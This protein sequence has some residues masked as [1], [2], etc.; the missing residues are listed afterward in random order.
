[1]GG[2]LFHS[3]NQAQQ[4]S[5]QGVRRMADR[6]PYRGKLRLVSGD[7]YA[8]GIQVRKDEAELYQS[9]RYCV[10]VNGHLGPHFRDAAAF[11]KAYI[12]SP[13]RSLSRLSNEHAVLIHDEQTG[14]V[15]FFTSLS[16]MRPL[17]FGHTDQQIA[18]ASE[19]RQ[20]VT[21][22]EIAARMDLEV[23]AQIA[24]EFAPVLTPWKTEFDSV[25]RCLP[26]NIYAFQAAQAEP[27][28]VGQYW[29][30]KQ[31]P[32]HDSSQDPHRLATALAATL[33]THLQGSAAFS[34]SGGL[35]SS[36]L[37]GL[38]RRHEL[39]QTSTAAHEAHAYTLSFPGRAMDETSQ[40]QDLVKSTGGNLHLIEAVQHNPSEYMETNLRL[41][42]RISG[43]ATLFYAHLLGERL[44]CDGMTQHISGI[45]AELWMTA[46]NHFPRDTL[47]AG[48]PLSALKQSWLFFDYTSPA[49]R[50]TARLKQVARQLLLPPG[51]SLRNP[52]FRP[53]PPAW[54]HRKWFDLYHQTEEAYQLKAPGRTYQETHREK[55][56]W[57]QAIRSGNEN[58]AQLHEYY[59]L[60]L[61]TPFLDKPIASL[62]AALPAE[63]IARGNRQKGLLV[64]ASRGYITESIRLQQTKTVHN[65]AFDLDFELLDQL[66][67]SGNQWALNDCQIVEPDLFAR[68]R[69]ESRANRKITT[70]L[71]NLLMIEHFLR[72]YGA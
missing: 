59:G 7:G 39:L 10:A 6:S 62:S 58:L 54:L 44:R 29:S 67:N 56:L 21:G 5:I 47:A 53:R 4:D 17:Y 2:I 12:E 72:R 49:D 71:T 28:A 14:Q 25:S 52:F 20:V 48:K 40:V 9:D 34:L 36:T 65:E 18:V 70:N 41:L 66:E 32:I 15:R 55:G 3:S 31:E 19:I 30:F 61:H 69:N 60:E 45:G 64:A 68:L 1:M 23:I 22:L 38:A 42:D 57:H 50:A 35:D 33:N 51:R 24:I 46:S 43:T 37:W 8:I 27:E 16:N 13:S 26:A 11:L 63:R